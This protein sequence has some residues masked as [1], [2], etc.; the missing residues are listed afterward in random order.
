MVNGKT[1]IETHS[2]FSDVWDI[3]L[4]Y[5]YQENLNCQCKV[6][7]EKFLNQQ[8]NSSSLNSNNK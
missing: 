2:Q 4:K 6:F 3:G 8:Y 1:I 5:F 7:M